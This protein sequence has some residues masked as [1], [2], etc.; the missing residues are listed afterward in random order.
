MAKYTYNKIIETMTIEADKPIKEQFEELT[1]I[2][3]AMPNSFGDAL[4]ELIQ[5]RNYSNEQLAERSFLSEKTI[6]RLRGDPDYTPKLSAVVAV[7]IGLNIP[8]CVSYPLIH[9]AGLEFNTTK[10][11]TA[12]QILLADFYRKTAHECNRI[13][14]E[15]GVAQLGKEK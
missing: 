2:I 11:H 8:P 4:S 9:R 6:R 13:L 1:G 3:K 5:L 14:D 10:V 7:C 12:Y 15:M